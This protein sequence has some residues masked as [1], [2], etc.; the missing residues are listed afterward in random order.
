MEHENR[1]Y[2]MLSLGE[3]TLDTQY[4]PHGP[5]EVHGQGFKVTWSA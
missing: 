1:S 2:E 4:D 3:Q 5:P